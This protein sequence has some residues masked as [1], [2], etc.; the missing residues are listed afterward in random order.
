MGKKN[1]FYE[2]EYWKKG[3]KDG[4][5]FV[6]GKSETQKLVAQMKRDGYKTR[7]RPASQKFYR[8]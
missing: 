5:I 1:S 6:S 4:Q 2:V 8:R 3:E 7:Y